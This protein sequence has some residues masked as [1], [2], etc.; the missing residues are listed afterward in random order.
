MKTLTEKQAKKIGYE[1]TRG[2]YTGTTDDRADRWYIA[3]IDSV[4]VDRR[5]AGYCTKR[6]ALEA[7]TVDLLPYPGE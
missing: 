4:I 3:K 7:L 1:I 2:A 5:G 6:A